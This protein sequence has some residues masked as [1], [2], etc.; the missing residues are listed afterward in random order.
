MDYPLIQ[1]GCN[2]CGALTRVMDCD[3]RLPAGWVVRGRH[4]HYCPTCAKKHKEEED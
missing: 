3:E 1:Y 2:D 4:T